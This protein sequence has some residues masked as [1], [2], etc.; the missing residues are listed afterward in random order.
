MF[1]VKRN[2]H[3]EICPIRG[4]ERYMEVTRDIMVNFRCG[5]LFRPITPD[6]GINDVP[7][8]SPVAESRL[9]GYLKEMNADNGETLHDFRSG[10]VITLALIHLLMFSPRVGGGGLPTGN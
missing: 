8:T 1:G 10:C 3:A 9:K 7:F 6:L 2:A 5:Y 4:I